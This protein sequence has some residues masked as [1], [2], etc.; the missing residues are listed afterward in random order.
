MILAMKVVYKR[1]IVKITKLAK[2]ERFYK[3]NNSVQEFAKI[4]SWLSKF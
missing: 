3:I 2:L 1:E 4:E